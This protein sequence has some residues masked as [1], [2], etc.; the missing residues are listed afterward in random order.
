MTALTLVA[1]IARWVG[2]DIALKCLSSKRIS[3]AFGVTRYLNPTEVFFFRPQSEYRIFAPLFDKLR[4]LMVH[5]VGRYTH[6]Y[7]RKK[8]FDP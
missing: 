5:A 2:K 4:S 1:L 3:K 8:L 6:L 7:R